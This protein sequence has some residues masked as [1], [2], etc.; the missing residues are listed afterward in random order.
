M[1]RRLLTDF[2]MPDMGQVKSLMEKLCTMAFWAAD[3]KGLGK[4]LRVDS[5][6][7]YA[8]LERYARDA[9]GYQRIHAFL[10]GRF[11]K[12]MVGLSAAQQTKFFAWRDDLN[13]ELQNSGIRIPSTNPYVQK[14]CA[15]LLYHLTIAKPFYIEGK[16]DADT[17]GER[18]TYFNAT[19]STYIANAMLACCGLTFSP[20]KDLL[21][22]LTH[23]LLSRS[24]MEALM[25]V[26]IRS[27][28]KHALSPSMKQPPKPAPKLA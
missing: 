12:L 15:F 24:A 19:A 14:K 10:D 6:S 27:A 21:R 5:L 1:P 23:R 11:D 13:Q 20:S 25:R 9:Y 26:A 3:E 28:A 7:L 17:I 8:A 22:D 2:F 18:I 16:A 4:R